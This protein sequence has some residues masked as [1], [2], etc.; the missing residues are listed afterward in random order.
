[1]NACDL[2]S[3]ERSR[4]AVA[5]APVLGI[6]FTMCV[7]TLLLD[8]RPDTDARAR[9]VVETY[10]DSPR[11]LLPLLTTHFGPPGTIREFTYMPWRQPTDTFV[12]AGL[13]DLI[14]S[15]LTDLGTAEDPESLLDAWRQ[16]I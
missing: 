13:R 10:A 16:L 2:P 1:M 8:F 5:A 14:V 4:Q 9:V 7:K 11:A 15:R 12:A 6:A 3:P